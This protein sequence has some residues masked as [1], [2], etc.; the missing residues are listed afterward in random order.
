MFQQQEPEQAVQSGGYANS[1]PVTVPPIVEESASYSTYA[2]VADQDIQT[3]SIGAL[4]VP[5]PP[6]GAVATAVAAV[7]DG[8]KEEA[9]QWSEGSIPW[10]LEKLGLN[11]LNDLLVLS[12]LDEMFDKEGEKS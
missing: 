7:D 12:G 10:Q 8:K 1:E 9:S 3:N 6:G 4:P 2:P 5:P 11:T